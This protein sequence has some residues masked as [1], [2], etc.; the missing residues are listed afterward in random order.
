MG[1]NLIIGNIK[2][3]PRPESNAAFYSDNTDGI[4][5]WVYNFVSKQKSNARL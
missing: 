2:H 3:R 4:L 1:R 5:S